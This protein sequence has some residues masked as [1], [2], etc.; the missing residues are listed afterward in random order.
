MQREVPLLPE[1]FQLAMLLSLC[2]REHNIESA[3]G[4]TSRSLHAAAMCVG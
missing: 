3:M 1:E 4:I 2:C